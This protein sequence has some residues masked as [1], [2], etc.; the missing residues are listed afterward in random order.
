MKLFARRPIVG[1]IGCLLSLL[2]WAI[3][4]GAQTLSLAVAGRANANV[5][6]AADG[7]FVAAA[8]SASSSDGTTDIY[9]AVS[10]DGGAT[11]AVP[12]RVNSTVG[13]A[14]VNGEQP[15]RVG[16]IPSGPAGDRGD[17]EIVVIWTAKGNA[18][19]TLLTARSADG[20][21]TFSR[22][23]VVPGT[24]AAGNRGWQA[25]TVDHERRVYAAWLDHRRLAAREASVASAH[26]HRADGAGGTAA[27]ETDGAAM[28]QLSELYV[29]RLGAAAS[30][31][32]VTGGVCYCCKTAMVA[33]QSGGLLV[34]W[35]H[36]YP[37]NLR[38]IAFT[39]SRDGGRTFAA[40]VRVSEDQWAIAGCPDDGP[41]I[42]VE[43]SGRVHVVWP[44]VVT[45]QGEMVKAIFHATSDEGRPFAARRRV[46]TLGQANHPQ[47]AIGRSGS[48]A[49]AWDESGSMPRRVV[50]AWGQAGADGRVVWHREVVSDDAGGVYPALTSSADRT[51]IAWTSGPP[52]RSTIRVQVR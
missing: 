31:V 28:A 12:V 46:P 39:Q 32:P 49:L 38:D 42:G 51:I 4:P 24:D 7:R 37:G 14:R 40:P 25:L 3:G 1:S 11:F 23:S 20:G 47:L 13:E 5:S 30:A 17:P 26:Q 18:G 43:P 16:L 15:P 45:E 48:I 22:S 21:S 50:F 6:L 35:R 9:V 8:W 41:A 44:T 34:A 2:A 52:D 27:R 19:T 10:R 33:S 29:A 36:V